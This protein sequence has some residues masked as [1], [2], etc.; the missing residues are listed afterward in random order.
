MNERLKFARS[1]WQPIIPGIGKNCSIHPSAEIGKG[2]RIDDNVV[3]K[4]NVTIGDNCWIFPGAVIGTSGFGFER[5][6]NGIPIR[7]HHD[8][9]VVIGNNV[10]IGTNSCVIKG[11]VD[12][13]IIMDDVKIDTLCIVAH[14][15]FIAK[16]T[17]IASGV[18]IGGSANIGRRCFIG[19]GCSIKNKV[20]I[21]NDVTIGQQ[22]NVVK[23]V[24]SGLTII[25]NPGREL[26]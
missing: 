10:E 17:L 2:T 13:T 21:G 25:G 9:G 5:D 18:L 14:N 6:E 19:T 7:I 12:L 8:G 22:T 16:K 3:I 15:V 26:K 23:D 20:V 4:E 1:R 24:H 11:T